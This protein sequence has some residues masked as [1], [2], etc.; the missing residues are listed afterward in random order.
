ME[1]IWSGS[2]TWCQ[3]GESL[4]VATDCQAASN[5]LQRNHLAIV[6]Q[7]GNIW[8]LLSKS[9]RNASVSEKLENSAS[10]SGWVSGLAVKL[11]GKI[12]VIMSSDSVFVFN[13]YCM[14]I[15]IY[16]PDNLVI[17][18]ISFLFGWVLPMKWTWFEQI[19]L[20]NIFKK[21][22]VNKNPHCDCNGERKI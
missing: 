15:T 18:M 22:Q 21:N 19:E 4:E 17:D 10:S 6:S 9:Y 14:R 11:F 8:E 5:D 1:A 3:M 20:S 2:L 7:E 12:R 13:D 16:S